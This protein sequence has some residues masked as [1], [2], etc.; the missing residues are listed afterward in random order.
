MC[1]VSFVLFPV[2]LPYV[3]CSPASSPGTGSRG[4]WWSCRALCTSVRPAASPNRPRWFLEQ[5]QSQVRINNSG[6]HSFLP[7]DL[8]HHHL[9]ILI[10]FSISCILTKTHTTALIYILCHQTTQSRPEPL[11][12]PK[13]KQNLLPSTVWL[14]MVASSLKLHLGSRLVGLCLG[15]ALKLQQN[16][17]FVFF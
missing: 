14:T 6:Q 11:W 8:T 5:T 17:I 12:G 9:T 10:S 15:P 13:L 16:N 4:N 1:R 2:P 3:S 7:L